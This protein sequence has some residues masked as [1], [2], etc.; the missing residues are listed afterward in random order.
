MQHF[1]SLREFDPDSIKDMIGLACKIKSD[2][3]SYSSALKGKKLYLLFQ[4]TSTRTALS[5]ATG[6]SDLGGQ[7][8]LQNWTDSNFAVGEIRDE[9]RYVGKNVDIITARLRRYDDIITM[10]KYSL[11]P[12]I[13]GCCDKYHPCQAMA[14]MMT[15]KEIFGTYAVSVL[16][17]GIKNNVLNS[18]METLPR[19]GSQLFS[20]TP[21]QNNASLDAN[22]VREVTATGNYQEI[23]PDMMVGDLQSIIRRVDIVYV[24][25]WV[26]MEYF[27]DPAYS[28]EKSHRINRMSPFQLT[29]ELLEGS[30]ALVM[31][32]MP[33]HAGYE[34]SRDIVEAHIETILHQA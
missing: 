20:F 10:S 26:D 30:H 6:M 31:H 32:D 5:F 22:L 33:V 3:G 7:Y 17:I 13:D 2:P 19:L 28:I 21:I 25:T 27:N 16:Y 8:F 24:D 11:V 23:S 34:I 18:L 15:I 29:A 9:V 4:K 14:D 12:V 1:V